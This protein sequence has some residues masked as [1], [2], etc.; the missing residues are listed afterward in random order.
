MRRLTLHALTL[1][2]AIGTG[3]LV[4]WAK[5]PQSSTQERVWQPQRTEWGEPD[6]EGMWLTINTSG[7]PFQ[8]PADERDESLLRELVDG[9]VVEP[10]LLNEG[11]PPAPREQDR[12]SAL[13]E[14]R[15]THFAWGTLVM[16]PQDGR[17]PSLTSTAQHRAQTEWRSSSQTRGPWNRA[18]DLGPAERC[19]SR[20]VLGSMLP[21]YD[22]HGTEIV[23]SPGIVVIRSEAM[24]EARVVP[25]DGRPPLDSA[26]RS[27]MGDGRGYWDNDT[28]VIETTNLNGRTGAHFGGNEVPTGPA[29]RLIEHFTRVSERV[30]EYQ[31]T[32]EDSETWSAPWSVAFP[33]TRGTDYGWSE[34]ACHEGNYALRHILSAARAAD[35]QAR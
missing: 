3:G 11:V 2:L 27:Y 9:G 29:L 26:I 16:E 7:V 28:L 1:A 5:A 21:A 14:W 33:L 18:A 23:Q 25:L 19:I 4:A 12:R 10:T 30:I 32:V 13:E 22:Y 20:G 15:R 8:R 35:E 34:Y 24:H 6:L 17:L 31:I